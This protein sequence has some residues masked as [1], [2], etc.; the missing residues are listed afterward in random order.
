MTT[1]IITFLVG[2]PYKP[3][4]PTVTVRGPHPTNKP[5]LRIPSNQPVKTGFVVRWPENSRSIAWNSCSV[6]RFWLSCVQRRTKSGS[7]GR[8]RSCE[9]VATGGV[10]K[11]IP[12]IWWFTLPETHIA[13]NGWLEDDPASFWGKRP[14]FRGKLAVRF[15]EG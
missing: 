12:R 6:K 8:P 4:F 15:R 1:R 3:A 2:N 5:F 14:I 13:Q 9:L 10:C 7:T 11:L